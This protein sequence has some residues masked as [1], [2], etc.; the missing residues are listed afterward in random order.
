MMIS[1]RNSVWNNLR[2]FVCKLF[3]LVALEVCVVCKHCIT[4]L[5]KTNKQLEARSAW[6]FITQWY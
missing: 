6:S 1:L 5:C 4:S 3:H 2:G